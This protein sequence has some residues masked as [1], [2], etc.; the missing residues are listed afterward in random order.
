METPGFRLEKFATGRF[1][2]KAPNGLRL[3]SVIG[4]RRTWCAEI[5]NRVVGY[6]RSP[7]AA[8]EALVKEL[9]R[10]RGQAC[11]D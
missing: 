5:G 10:R 9:A 6:F 7:R 3:G 11:K 4:G 8:G 2:V 1:D